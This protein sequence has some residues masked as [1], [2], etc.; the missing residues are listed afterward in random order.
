M[1]LFPNIDKEIYP[2]EREGFIFNSSKEFLIGTFGG[3]QNL[4]LDYIIHEKYT[5]L[6]S[7]SPKLTKKIFPNTYKYVKDE[8]N[9]N[10][11]L[12]VNELKHIDIYLSKGQTVYHGGLFPLDVPKVGDTISIS[13]IFSATIDP[14]TATQ[15]AFQ[16]CDNFTCYFWSITLSKNT[17]VYPAN[18]EDQNESEVIILDGLNLKIVDIEQKTRCFHDNIE[19]ITFVFLE[20]I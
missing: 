5:L 19:T 12:M 4:S 20:Q 15:H 13:Q 10:T 8:R 17:R 9:K 1:F 7:K 6:L 2:I 11:K 3:L 14:T 18:I 16:S